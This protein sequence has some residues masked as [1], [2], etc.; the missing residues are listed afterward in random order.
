MTS[1]YTSSPT[2]VM[3]PQQTSDQYFHSGHCRPFQP[4]TQ[5]NGLFNQS[6][7]STASF[8]PTPSSGS[9]AGRK[10]SRGDDEDDT[11]ETPAAASIIIPS[12]APTYGPGMTLSYPNDPRGHYA[13]DDHVEN[14]AAKSDR[15]VMPSRKSQ[16]TTAHGSENL[17]L[18]PRP[19][20]SQPATQNDSVIDKVTRVLGVSW[21]R[22]D[23]YEGGRISQRAY[24]RWIQCHYP[25]LA[26]VEL[27][28]ENSSIPGYFGTAFNQALGAQDYL[29]WSFDLKQAVSITTNPEDI[30]SK[31]SAR[32]LASLVKS[33][34]MT[35]FASE[36][37]VFDDSTTSPLAQEIPTL[38]TG[39]M[40]I[41][42]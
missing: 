14:P 19:I 1:F 2:V 35:I 27:W 8:Q 28:F 22:M 3:P 41:D 9:I 32:N 23:R 39:D 6:S 4:N 25:G 38:S 21:M 40:E 11:D 16:R 15:P 17:S 18:P 33:A 36:A 13:V 7:G 30:S 24:T 34:S 42:S 26:N 37:P 20:L 10:R 31:L 12:V 5:S 29:I